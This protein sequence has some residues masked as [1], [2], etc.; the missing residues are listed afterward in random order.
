MMAKLIFVDIPKITRYYRVSIFDTIRLCW[1]GHS[2]ED[3]AVYWHTGTLTCFCR[4][5]E[6][7]YPQ[8]RFS[9]SIITKRVSTSNATFWTPST[10]PPQ[11]CGLLGRQKSRALY[12][13]WNEKKSGTTSSWE[14]LYLDSFSPMC[15]PYVALHAPWN[16]ILGTVYIW[17]FSFMTVL[18]LFFGGMVCG[19]KCLRKVLNEMVA[20]PASSAPASFM[21]RSS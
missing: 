3:R 4:L 7:P 16:R 5:H 9:K 12:V 21:V 20:T 17:P 13:N 6:I 15:R 14:F 11:R 2:V 1:Y 8:N 18:G 19:G 10:N